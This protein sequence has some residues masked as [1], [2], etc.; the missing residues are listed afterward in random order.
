MQVLVIIQPVSIW[1]I[2]NSQPV[3]VIMRILQ[4]NEL[5]LLLGL[6]KYRFTNQNSSQSG[7][8]LYCKLQFVPIPFPQPSQDHPQSCQIKQ[9]QASHFSSPFCSLLPGVNCL[10]PFK[11]FYKGVPHGSGVH[12]AVQHF[13]VNQFL[14]STPVSAHVQKSFKGNRL[15][16]F[17]KC[18]SCRLR[19]VMVPT[20]HSSLLFSYL[21]MTAVLLR[22]IY[23]ICICILLVFMSFNCLACCIPP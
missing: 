11:G 10:K 14:D 2:Q 4:H 5:A 6:S 8:G 17:C 23:T 18:V 9:M 7:S 12:A 19:A 20:W 13:W 22:C 16:G 21:P 1:E 15:K 3:V